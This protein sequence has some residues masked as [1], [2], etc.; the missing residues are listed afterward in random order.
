MSHFLTRSLQERL[1]LVEPEGASAGQVLKAVEVDGVVIFQPGAD[2]AGG[3]G[4]VELINLTDTHYTLAGDASDTGLILSYDLDGLTGAGWYAIDPG[5][6]LQDPMASLDAGEQEASDGKILQWV[7]NPTGGDG[8][9]AGDWEAQAAPA[10][11]A[12]DLAFNDLT[13]VVANPS[14][15]TGGELLTFI[16][17]DPG[18]GV[19]GEGDY[20]PATPEHFGMQA[21]MGGEPKAALCAPAEIQ[22]EPCDVPTKAFDLS[23]GKVVYLMGTWGLGAE[24]VCAVELT[25]GGEVGVGRQCFIVD[26]GSEVDRMIDITVAGGTING[27]AEPVQLS[28]RAAAHLLCTS[29]NDPAVDAGDGASTWVIL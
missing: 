5:M 28:D 14:V 10:A 11:D 8:S 12:P 20:V 6:P 15:L 21:S 24:E 18:H 19:E 23:D 13:D 9:G 1:D 4:V 7:W 17:A 16:P 3:G 2:E 25:M 26:D 22:L 29:Y 27:S